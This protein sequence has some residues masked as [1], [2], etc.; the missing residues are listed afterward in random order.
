MK[1]MKGGMREWHLSHSS[2]IVRKIKADKDR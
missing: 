2:N 1:M